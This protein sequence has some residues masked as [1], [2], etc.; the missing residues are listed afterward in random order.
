[1][2]LFAAIPLHDVADSLKEINKEFQD[3][4]HCLKPVK[5]NQFHLTLKF[6]GNLKSYDA[7]KVI[8]TFD[9]WNGSVETFSADLKGLGV[10]PSFSQPS[11]IWAGLEDKG[12]SIEKIYKDCQNIFSSA[13]F[14]I[15]TRIFHPHLTLSR[16]K[17][18]KHAP[19]DLKNLIKDYKDHLFST[20]QVEHIILYE[21]KLHSYG[22]EYSEI[23]K[24]NFK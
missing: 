7:E 18:N 16:I 23:R 5:E 14:E 10:F 13:G 1:V 11:V 8:E 20:L 22:P 2:R 12:G 6:F 21:S 19:D 3:F 15:D 4:S 24:I 17:K 9:S